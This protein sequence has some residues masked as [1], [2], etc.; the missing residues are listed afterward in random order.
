[1]AKMDLKDQERPRTRVVMARLIRRDEDDGSFD[2]EFWDRVGPE[3]RFSAA[4][5]MVR[6]RFAMRGMDADESRLQRSVLSV[7][8]R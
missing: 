6:E 7:Q 5:D 8:R 4:W 3:G 2:L 1:M